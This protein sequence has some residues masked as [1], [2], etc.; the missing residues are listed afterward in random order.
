MYHSELAAYNEPDPSLTLDMLEVQAEEAREKRLRPS[1]EE[2]REFM[3]AKELWR[4]L[5][6]GMID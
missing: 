5:Q 2:E 3:S 4:E 1:P 6:E